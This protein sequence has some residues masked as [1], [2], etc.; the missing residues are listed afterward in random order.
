MN[1]PFQRFQ[2]TKE[3]MMQN[4]LKN[5]FDVKK[6]VIAFMLIALFSPSKLFASSPN[7]SASARI[8]TTLIRI[9]EQ[10]HM[11]LNATVPAGTKLLFPVLPD[12]IKKLEIVGRSKIDT[13]KSADGKTNT[14]H[15]QLTLTSFDSG[16]YVIEPI[17]FYFRVPGKADSDSVST[18]AQLITVRTIPVDTTQAIKDIKAT[19]DVPLTF[20]EV[21]PY[22]IGM[23]IAVILTIIIIRQLKKRKKKVVEVKVKIPSRPA[24]EIAL[25]EL[26]KTEEEKLWQQGYFKKY[27]SA[28]ADIIRTYIEH[29]FS[30]N[31]ME[32][33]TDETLDHL[34][35]NIINEEAKQKLANLLRFADMV[36]F[37]KVQPDAHENEQSI[38]DAYDFIM[39]TKPATAD[40]FKD[41][42]SS[43][44]NA[45]KEVAS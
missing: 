8:D 31:A 19:L 35:G 20:R 13:S 5:I 2:L 23:L 39:L 27:Q 12:T 11:H 38:K 14:L 45:E 33:T 9:G 21:L 34:R 7:V 37:A 28:V 25:E 24:H 36:K 17:P 30:I 43:V 32:Y 4:F 26:K 41:T 3:M 42:N 6:I 44:T 18:E 15:Q 22:I 29:R 16:F 1:K 40:D 10:F